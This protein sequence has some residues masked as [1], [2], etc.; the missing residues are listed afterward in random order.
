MDFLTTKQAAKYLG[1]SESFLEKERC[2]GLIKI[3][4]VKLGR[5]VRYRKIDLD[6]FANENV[7]LNTS[8]TEKMG[9]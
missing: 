3:P 6:N 2:Y 9:A 1:I 8:Q 4:F 7:R 5:T